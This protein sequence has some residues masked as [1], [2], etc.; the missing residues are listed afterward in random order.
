LK[1]N[2][3][4]GKDKSL[5]FDFVKDSVE[6]MEE[7][8]LHPPRFSSLEVDPVDIPDF[9]NVQAQSEPNDVE[10]GGDDNNELIAHSSLIR[11]RSSE[12]SLMDR[13]G[14]FRSDPL[15]KVVSHFTRILFHSSFLIL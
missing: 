2:L 1:I 5:V 10:K 7:V 4:P 12:V 13:P 8:V 3:E 15:V 6:S 9:S 14:A 11:T